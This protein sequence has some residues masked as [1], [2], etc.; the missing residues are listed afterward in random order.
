MLAGQWRCHCT[1][2]VQYKRC[3]D[4]L[5]CEDGSDEENCTVVKL[6]PDYRRGDPPRLEENVTNLIGEIT[7]QSY[8]GWR[9]GLL[10]F[11]PAF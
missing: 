11:I 1:V 5:D 4:K 3:N 9:L 6:R 7:D 8:Q 2:T 10:H